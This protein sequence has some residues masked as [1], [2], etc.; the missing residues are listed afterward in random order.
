[1]PY[2]P[3]SSS[4]TPDNFRI[5]PKIKS[6]EILLSFLCL[7]G[8]AMTPS[9]EADATVGRADF[10]GVLLIFSAVIRRRVQNRPRFV[11]K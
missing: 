1:V 9:C 5:T 4:F 6:M 11:E 3:F 2:Q 7:L 8:G 10:P